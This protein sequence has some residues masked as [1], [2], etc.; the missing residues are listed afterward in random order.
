VFNDPTSSIK[1]P[2]Y[3]ESILYILNMTHKQT[4]ELGIYMTKLFG[5]KMGELQLQVSFYVQKLKAHRN[6]ACS[7]L[8][9]H[10]F[11]MSLSTHFGMF[12]CVITY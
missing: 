1:P 9:L 12:H 11:I 7:L 6:N 5:K 8:F 10:V 3:E 4:T 2:K